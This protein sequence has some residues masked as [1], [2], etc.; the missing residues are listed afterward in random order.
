MSGLV[1]AVNAEAILVASILAA[2]PE[3]TLAIVLIVTIGQV[4][5]K[6]LL[7]GGGVSLAGSKAAEKLARARRVAESL[8]DRPLVLGVAFLASATI[9]LPPL[10]VMAIVAGIARLPLPVFVVL[11]FVGRFV[12]FY[13]LAGVTDSF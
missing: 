10:Y 1:P 5:A 7:Y 11:C 9:G 13:A 2:P 8:G 12:R 4:A 6:L 3:M